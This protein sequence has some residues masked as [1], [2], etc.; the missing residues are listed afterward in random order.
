MDDKRAFF[1]VILAEKWRRNFWWNC[2]FRN[3]LHS[4]NKES[5]NQL[6]R[7]VFVTRAK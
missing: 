6:E 1:L 2:F 4:Q 7:V 3:W 5:L